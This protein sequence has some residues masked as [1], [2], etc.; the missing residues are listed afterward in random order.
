MLYLGLIV[1]IISYVILITVVMIYCYYFF[2]KNWK[3]AITF[4]LITFMTSLFTSMISSWMIIV[5]NGDFN[6]NFGI[7][8]SIVPFIFVAIS[9]PL[10]IISSLTLKKYKNSDS[11]L[12]GVSNFLMPALTLIGIFVST[13]VLSYNVSY[14]IYIMK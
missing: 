13:L 9:M 1:T 6:L 5:M 10:L 14:F 8:F 4:E 11:I 12:T 7:N 3:K 2:K